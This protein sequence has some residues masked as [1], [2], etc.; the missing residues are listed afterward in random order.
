MHVVDLPMAQ[1]VMPRFLVLSLPLQWHLKQQVLP[2]R[3]HELLQLDRESL[4]N[5]KFVPQTKFPLERS[6]ALVQRR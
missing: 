3:R 4:G 5:R 2:D 6:R 1:R